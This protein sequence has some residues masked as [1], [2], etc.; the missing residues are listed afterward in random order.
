[1]AGAFY[2]HFGVWGAIELHGQSQQALTAM[3]RD[4]RLMTEYVT[5]LTRFSRVF[6]GLGLVFL[7]WACLVEKLLPSWLVFMGVLLGVAGMALTMGLPDHLYLYAPLF[8][9]N[10]GWL[11]VVG[12]VLFQSKET[13]A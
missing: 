6:F 8:H 11:A 12:G 13:H 2:Y 9:L 10:A 7:A 3:I 5:C 4:L 1:M